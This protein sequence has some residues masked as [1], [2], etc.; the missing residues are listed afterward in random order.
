MGELAKVIEID[1]RKIID[2]GSKLSEIK[3]IF[4]TMTIEQGTSLTF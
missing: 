3:N 1:R 4:H 2:R